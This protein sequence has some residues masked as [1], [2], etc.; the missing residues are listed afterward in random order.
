MKVVVTGGTGHLGAYVVRKLLDAAHELVCLV[1]PGSAEKL[2]LLAREVTLVEADLMSPGD[3][4]KAFEGAGGWVHLI[5]TA[6]EDPSKGITYEGERILR[7]AGKKAI[8]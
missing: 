8:G 4:E 2:G 3:W 1:R 5:G 7:K 6:Y